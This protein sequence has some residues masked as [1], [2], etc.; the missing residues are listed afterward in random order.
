NALSDLASSLPSRRVAVVG[1][2]M[3]DHFLI[4]RVDRIS[5]EAP[6]PVVRFERDEYRL[7]G[8]ANVAHNI[9][10]LGARADLIGIVGDDEGAL[11][12]A[13]EL[14]AAHLSADGLVTDTTRATTRKTRIVTTRNQQVARVDQETDGDATTATM[15]A[16]V[17]RL[18]KIAIDANAIVLSDYRKGA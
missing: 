17:A 7:G 6:V 14:K 16:M 15:E 13:R 3:L 18:D 12:I 2:V 5:P 4:G 1:D 11:H 9:A 8:A 10:A